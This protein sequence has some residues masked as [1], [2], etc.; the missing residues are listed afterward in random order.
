MVGER[1]V[2]RVRCYALPSLHTR[3]LE[4]VH[5]QLNQARCCGRNAIISP[6]N[7]HSH[8]AIRICQPA[9][10][11]YCNS[12]SGGNFST[13]MDRSSF[14]KYCILPPF[15]IHTGFLT[16]IML[17]VN[18]QQITVTCYAKQNVYRPQRISMYK[19]DRHIKFENVATSFA[20]ET[21]IHVICIV[22]TPVGFQ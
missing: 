16:M 4:A 6:Q 15:L 5:M 1:L 10:T 13:Q 17:I 19:C 3:L 14:C 22:H 18:T 7:R 21:I 2:G 12:S 11:K 20:T 9:S 8:V